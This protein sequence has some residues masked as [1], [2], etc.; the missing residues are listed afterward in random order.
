MKYLNFRFLKDAYRFLAS[1]K[2]EIES[3][4]GIPVEWMELLEKKASRIKA[5]TPGL[6]SNTGD[7][8]TY[9]AWMLRTA[10]KFQTVFGKLLKEYK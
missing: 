9:F 4:L 8:E 5:E 10:E 6:I 1:R 7:R 3:A 2:A